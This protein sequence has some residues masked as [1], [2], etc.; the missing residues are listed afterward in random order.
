MKFLIIRLSSLGDIILTQPVLA[1]ISRRYHSA[2]IHYVCKPQYADIPRMMGTNI[3]VIPYEKSIHW[4]IHLRRHQYHAVLDLHCK[5]GSMI[6]SAMCKALR[7]VR[8]RK[9]RALRESIIRHTSSA[10]IRST[11]DLYYS[12]LSKL[13]QCDMMPAAHPRLSITSPSDLSLLPPKRPG[14]IRVGLFPGAAHP[15]KKYPTD[16][17][18]QLIR[19]F[20][21]DFEYLLM[22]GAEDIADAKMI[23]NEFP[24]KARDL[25]GKLNLN[26][27]ACA[28]GMCDIVL[29]GDTGPMHMAAALQ[30]KQVAVF[31]ST[32]PRLGFAPQN[33]NAA[34][35]C[36]DLPCQPCTLHGLDKC[37]LGHF[38]CMRSVSPES[39][40]EAIMNLLKQ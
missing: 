36:R 5:A 24:E 32:H 14:Y 8:Y 21:N 33:D 7:R 27:L 13:F 15:T 16:Q 22:G 17:W 31:G 26:E 12:A 19:L 34:V 6:I 40:A 25:C 39:V 1:E 3:T 37:P 30:V 9:L 23:Q 35:L 28:I 38:E 10:S 11:V 18:I 2:E 29:S 4:H 20:G